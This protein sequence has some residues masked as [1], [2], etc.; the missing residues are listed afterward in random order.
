MRPLNDN[1]DACTFEFLLNTDLK[2]WIPQTVVD[3]AL[4]S[5]LF[6]YSASLKEHCQTLN[7]FGET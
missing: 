6:E 3:A 4:I 7:T 2:G 5:V 1:A